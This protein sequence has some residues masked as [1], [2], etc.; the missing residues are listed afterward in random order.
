MKLLALDVGNT[1]V[2]C[3]LFKDG[4]IVRRARLATADVRTKGKAFF[5]K[6]FA[7][8]R[9]EAA[10]IGSVVPQAG[11]SLKQIL[12]AATGAKAYLIGKDLPVPIANRYRNPRQ[13]GADRLLNA[14]AAWEKYRRPAVVIDFGTAVT[15]DVVSP[16]GE[17]L[18]GVIAPGIEISLEA[19]FRKTALLP[20]TRLAHP[21]HVVGRDTVESIRSGCAYGIGG[22]CD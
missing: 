4:R 21:R 20:R 16:K 10:V 2:T 19:L 5:K 8:A 12:P 17:Y 9:P 18:G 7:A 3:A 22:L 14:L 1:S 11:L 13:V 6:H 15:F